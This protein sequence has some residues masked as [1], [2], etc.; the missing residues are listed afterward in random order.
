V[1]RRRFLFGSVACIVVAGCESESPPGVAP[2]PAILPPPPGELPD[3]VAPT[4]RSNRID[5]GGGV[6]PKVRG[7]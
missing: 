6:A 7:D 3:G 4:R 2:K 1:D 5:T